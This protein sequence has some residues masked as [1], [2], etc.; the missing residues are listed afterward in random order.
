MPKYNIDVSDYI[1]YEE[2][3]A[4]LNNGEDEIE[5]VLVSVTWLTGARPTEIISLKKKDILLTETKIEFIM[6]NL[7]RGKSDQFDMVNRKL[8]RERPIGVNI[9]IFIETIAKYIRKLPEEESLLF[10]YTKRWAEGKITK[11]C[12]KTLG[13]EKSMYHFRHGCHVWLNRHGFTL[14]DLQYWKGAKDVRSVLKYLHATARTVTAE[15]TQEDRGE[16]KQA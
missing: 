1:T 5:R 4:I 3:L 14:T 16:S 9:D 10:P 15:M 6:R 11:L 8:K 13:K 12:K 7:K 2:A